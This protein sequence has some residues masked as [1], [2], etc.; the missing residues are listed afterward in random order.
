VS[1]SDKPPVGSIGWCD[2]TVADADAVRAGVVEPACGPAIAGDL[3]NV[4]SAAARVRPARA[5]LVLT[6]IL[7]SSLAFVDSGR[8]RGVT[9]IGQA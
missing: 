9:A 3:C 7:A 1:G 2:L 6:A 8:Q 5:T 4:Q